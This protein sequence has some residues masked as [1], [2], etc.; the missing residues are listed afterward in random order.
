MVIRA[1]ETSVYK[2]CS[3]ADLLKNYY[4]IWT[5]AQIRSC[6]HS[7]PWVSRRKWSASNPQ[8]CGR[9]R[10]RIGTGR[11]QFVK[12]RLT[13][14]CWTSAWSC[15]SS[16][17]SEQTHGSNRVI[18]TPKKKQ[19]TRF[20]RTNFAYSSTNKYDQL[21]TVRRNSTPFEIWYLSSPDVRNTAISPEPW[22]A[23]KVVDFKETY[24]NPFNAVSSM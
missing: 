14:I 20:S 8:L 1:Y 5:K 17:T 24:G 18:F 10:F 6:V 16:A 2:F 3:G 21:K 11:R 12:D 15:D 22:C 4:Y 19:Y 7:P 13:Y 9:C 23:K